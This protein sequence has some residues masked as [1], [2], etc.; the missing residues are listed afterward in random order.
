MQD[1]TSLLAA[2]GFKKRVS[3]KTTTR[4]ADLRTTAQCC[5]HNWEERNICVDM[6]TARRE[7][8]CIC[9]NTTEREKRS[10]SVC[11]C[12]LNRAGKA[13]SKG[14]TR[15]FAFF[16]LTLVVPD[17][18]KATQGEGCAERSERTACQ[19]QLSFLRRSLSQSSREREEKS[20]S[21]CVWVT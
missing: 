6:W 18:S 10:V 17:K 11:T 2:V 16:A 14:V 20:V 9:A 5:K 8:K 12:Q 13:F 3:F 4:R 21:A 15:T 19:G 1:L 7:E